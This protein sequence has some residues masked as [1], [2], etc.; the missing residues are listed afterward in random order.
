[1]SAELAEV[2]H[3][4]RHAQQHGQRQRHQEQDRTVLC[5]WRSHQQKFVGG[6]SRVMVALDERL[7]VLP[8]IVLIRGVTKLCT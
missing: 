2:G 7:M 8:R 4:R 6:P 3:Q 5:T 1:M